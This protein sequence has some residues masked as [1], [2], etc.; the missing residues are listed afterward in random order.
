MIFFW[1]FILFG[2]FIVV[3]FE[4]SPE[5]QG[6][7]SSEGPSLFYCTFVMELVTV[8]IIPLSL[9]LFKFRK[10]AD[11]LKQRGEAA[12]NHW[13]QVR[14][15]LLALPMWVNVL[16]YYLSM[17]TTFGYMAIILLLCMPFVY[18]SMSRCL[19]EIE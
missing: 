3:A 10:I 9:R 7:L 18:P 17:N 1:A 14:L 16:F 5:I 19:S 15:C 6:V 8:C 13:G 2:L 4:S 12:L 11:D